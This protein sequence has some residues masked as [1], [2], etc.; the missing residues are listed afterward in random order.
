MKYNSL[1]HKKDPDINHGD[2]ANDP[3]L[4][5]DATAKGSVRKM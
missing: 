5:H 2:P 1:W 4:D 3:D